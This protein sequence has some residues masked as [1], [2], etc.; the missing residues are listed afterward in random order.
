MA[1]HGAIAKI[2][3]DMTLLTAEAPVGPVAASV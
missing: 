3:D 1:L 2:K